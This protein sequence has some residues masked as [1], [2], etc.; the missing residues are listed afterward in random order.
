MRG[1]ANCTRLS[2][3]AGGAVEAGDR[4]TGPGLKQHCLPQEHAHPDGSAAEAVLRV[5]PCVITSNTLNRIV[6]TAFKL[7]LRSQKAGQDFLPLASASSSFLTN[8]AGSFLKSFRQ[9]LQHNWISRP[10]CV[11]V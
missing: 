8:L 5:T 10:S 2:M 1:S 6:K 7:P 3:L 9:S 11:K 4:G